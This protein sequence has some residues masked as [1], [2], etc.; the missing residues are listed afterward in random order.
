MEYTLIEDDRTHKER[1]PYQTVRLSRV[2]LMITMCTGGI[3]P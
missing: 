1:H 2:F 3:L